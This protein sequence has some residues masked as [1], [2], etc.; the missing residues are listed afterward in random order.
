MSTA[1]SNGL[2]LGKVFVHPD[3]VHLMKLRCRDIWRTVRDLGWWIGQENPADL[4]QMEVNAF[5]FIMEAKNVCVEL[6]RYYLEAEEGFIRYA[7]VPFLPVYLVPDDQEK[8][9]ELAD[10][11]WRMVQTIQSKNWVTRIRGVKRLDRKLLDEWNSVAGVLESQESDMS[12]QERNGEF[13]SALLDGKL[14]YL[15][16]TPRVNF[17]GKVPTSLSSSLSSANRATNNGGD[18]GEAVADTSAVV[19][20][21]RETT[22]PGAGDKHD[23]DTGGRQTAE[24]G[25]GVGSTARPRPS[26][27]TEAMDLGTSEEDVGVVDTRERESTNEEGEGDGFVD[28]R[29]GETTHDEEVDNGDVQS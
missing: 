26:T 8:W 22:A 25:N 7:R 17:A 18:E 15:G 12:D 24:D 23:N 14:S 19:V 21:D 4:R 6:R 11:L 3:D 1:R 16:R 20:E 27:A 28:A 5:R 13:R 29:E 9:P 2:P 10:V